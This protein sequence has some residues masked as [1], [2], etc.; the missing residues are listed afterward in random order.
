MHYTTS[1]HNSINNFVVV[2]D[3]D[4]EYGWSR[5]RENDGNTGDVEIFRQVP[6]SRRIIAHMSCVLVLQMAIGVVLKL[7]PRGASTPSFYIQGG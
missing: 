2:S 3:N 7:S 6:T 5:D 1:H 4:L